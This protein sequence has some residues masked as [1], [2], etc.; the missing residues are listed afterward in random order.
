MLAKK[1]LIPGLLALILGGG[2]V[3]A[4]APYRA[5][6]AAATQA[7]PADRTKF[8][9]Q[10]RGDAVV[11]AGLIKAS[12]DVTGQKPRVIVRALRDGATIEG[13]AQAA[14]KSAADVLAAFDALVDQRMAKAVQSGRLPQSVAD[15]R[16]AWFKQSARL[17]IDQP[18]LQPPFP[19]LHEVHA[20]MITAAVNASGMSR[21][22][23]RAALEQCRNLAAIVASK[24]KSGADVTTAAMLFFDQRL[25]AA[26]DNGKLTSAQRD[27][28]RAA[29][30]TAAT[31]MVNTPGLHVA[32][33]E[34][35]Q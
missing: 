3:W 12:A 30:Q 22:D 1:W 9:A 28:W 10:P 15:S 4:I 25:Q 7:D 20:V 16:A 17:Q 29:L 11:R 14:G 26:V 13:S 35:A 6:A 34:C 32:G 27:E 8:G 24:G 33:K 19:G 18:G 5:A 2:V 31:N 23:I 21:A